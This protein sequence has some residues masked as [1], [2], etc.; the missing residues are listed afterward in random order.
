M[1]WT[2]FRY[3]KCKDD[4]D[5]IKYCKTTEVYVT[6]QRNNWWDDVKED[7]KSITLSQEDAQSEQCCISCTNQSNALLYKRKEK[8]REQPKIWIDDIKEKQREDLQ[9][10]NNAG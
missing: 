8:S 2:W 6:R 1:S 5:W 7:M 9:K 3:A 4:A 10:E